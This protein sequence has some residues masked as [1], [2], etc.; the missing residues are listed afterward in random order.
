MKVEKK[1]G[2][3]DMFHCKKKAE[4]GSIGLPDFEGQ[5]KTD[6][7]V[8]FVKLWK[9]SKPN[10]TNGEMLKGYIYKVEDED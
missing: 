7:G 9:E 1:L 10:V 2:Y 5:I 4:G 8:V 3:I 6:K